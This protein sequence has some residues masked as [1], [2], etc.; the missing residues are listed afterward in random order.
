[1]NKDPGVTGHD[2]KHS[3][4]INTLNGNIFGVQHSNRL[5]MINK[6]LHWMYEIYVF[7]TERTEKIHQTVS[8]FFTF[9]TRDVWT[10]YHC[11]VE[12]V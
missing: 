2:I 9:N 1:M 11:T 8:N 10:V 3:D 7:P 4:T 12:P 6:K 5:C